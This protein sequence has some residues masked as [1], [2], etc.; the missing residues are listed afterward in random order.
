MCLRSM[1]G[2]ADKYLVRIEPEFT[3]EGDASYGN[4]TR[5]LHNFGCLYSSFLQY[6]VDCMYM[7][8]G[9][10]IE[11]SMP[12][13]WICSD[14]LLFVLQLLPNID[15]DSFD[16]GIPRITHQLH[17]ALV[18]WGHLILTCPKHTRQVLFQCLIAY[19]HR[20]EH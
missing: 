13:C 8:Y 6:G 1:V 14:K 12:P 9:E 4:S 15:M 10:V 5:M 3:Q 2:D 20:M 7:V 17:G 16:L 19:S 11:S 18:W